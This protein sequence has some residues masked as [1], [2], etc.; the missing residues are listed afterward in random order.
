[1]LPPSAIVNSAAMNMGIQIPLENYAFN[2]LWYIPRSGTSGS[3]GN[4]IFIF[5][6]YLF[7]LFRVALTAYEGS[8]ARG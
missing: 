6:I 1:M 8:Q 3:Y 2:F 7:S 5:K 4:S